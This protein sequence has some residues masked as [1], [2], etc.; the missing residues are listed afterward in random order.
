[1]R[2]LIPRAVRQSGHVTS[3]ALGSCIERRA[4]QKPSPSPVNATC[5]F[6]CHPGKGAR[7]D[8]RCS[9][10]RTNLTARPFRVSSPRASLRARKPVEV[11]RGRATVIG[12]WPKVRPA[13]EAKRVSH[14]DAN[15]PRSID[16]DH[17][18]TSCADRG[19]RRDP[20]SAKCCPG[21]SSPD[22]F[23]CSASIL[24]APKRARPR[25]SRACTCMNSCTTAAICSASPATDGPQAPRSGEV[26]R[27]L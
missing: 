6:S 22:L 16:H 11:R 10:R 19:R 17:R 7:P 2:R 1:M 5:E 27:E 15:S 4:A 18:H 26:G 21:S 23:V 13:P 8:E 3:H 9:M 14:G 25:S 20:D 12:P 24:S